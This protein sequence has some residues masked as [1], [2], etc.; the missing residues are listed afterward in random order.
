MYFC[1]QALVW[2]NFIISFIIRKEAFASWM[3]ESFLMSHIMSVLI[4]GSNG[5]SKCNI[6]SRRGFIQSTFHYNE[7]KYFE[8]DWAQRELKR[9]IKNM[10]Q[11]FF[12]FLLFLSALIWSMI[13][14]K[15][16]IKV[17]NNPLWKYVWSLKLN[18]WNY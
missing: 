2:W 10:G 18:C 7:Y 1:R 9:T 13:A 6:V 16:N 17:L 3:W 14:E 11:C 5:E 15:I 12:S 4:C 8:H